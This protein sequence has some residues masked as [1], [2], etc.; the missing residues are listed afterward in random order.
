[1]YV[2]SVVVW[3]YSMVGFSL[4]I[5]Y[6]RNDYCIENSLRWCGI[7][8]WGAPDRFSAAAMTTSYVVTIGF[9]MYFCLKNTV[10]EILVA[11]V[12]FIHKLQHQ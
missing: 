11:R 4:N 3:L 8:F 9:V 1:M 6:M 2:V 10:P 7:L 5:F 12:S